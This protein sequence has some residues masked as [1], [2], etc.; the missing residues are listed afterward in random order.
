MLRGDTNQHVIQKHVFRNKNH[1]HVEEET[2]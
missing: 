2:R 1:T